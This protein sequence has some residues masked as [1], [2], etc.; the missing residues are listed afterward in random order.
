MS[1]SCLAANAEAPRFR[2]NAFLAILALCGGVFVF[3]LQ[4]VVIKLLSGAYPVHEVIVIR[5]F[6]ALP[7]LLFMIHRQAGLHAIIAGPLSWLFIRGLLLVVS[8]TTY[9]LAFPVM[10]L[11][12]IVA[13]YF[14]VPIFVTA[15]AGPFLGEKIGWSRWLA[16]GVGFCGVVVMLRPG[17]GVL[18]LVALLPLV[19]ACSY[20]S[21]QLMTRRYSTNA[22]ALV[23]S[24]YQNLMFLAAAGLMALVMLAFFGGGIVPRD[25]GA[26]DFLLR[27]WTMPSF[28]DLLLL[29]ACGPISAIAMTLLSQ[30]YRLTEANFVTPFEYSGL[31]WAALWG[32]AIFGE[33]PDMTMWFGAALI[34]GA[35]LYMLYGGARRQA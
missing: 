31:I 12:D 30:A 27:P 8:Y 4:D 5:C 9:Y 20:G 17:S 18:N 11:A 14:T 21:A 16:T 13:L 26:L 1:Q 24:F 33:T 3:S 32:Y 25:N 22:P 34:V 7:I 28:R 2:H 35:G 6:S 15:L 29:A 10:P 19:A 23:M